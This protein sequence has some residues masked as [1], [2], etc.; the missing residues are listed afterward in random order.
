MYT[1]C[2]VGLSRSF[3]NVVF[4][5]PTQ[6]LRIT[7][8]G[9]LGNQLF[10]LAAGETLSAQTNRKMCITSTLACYTHSQTLY[11]DTLLSEWKHLYAQPNESF[12]VLQEQSYRLSSWNGRI[13]ASVPYVAVEG[14]FQSYEYIPANFVERL[15]L[16]SLAPRSSDVFLHIRGGDYVNNPYH[17]V[18]LSDNYYPMAIKQFPESTH[19]RVFTND[20]KYAESMPFL[21]TISHSFADG[22]ELEALDQMRHCAGGICANSTFSW[23]GAYLNPDRKIVLPSKWFGYPIADISGLFVPGW[24]ICP[25]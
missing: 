16:P 1:A 5:C 20:R 4:V 9:G 24:T 7:L 2:I 25:V 15:R 3:L 22:D 21:K 10:Q 8:N 14:Y 11:F 17:D 19:F 6:M 12:S 23:W 13:L 18:R